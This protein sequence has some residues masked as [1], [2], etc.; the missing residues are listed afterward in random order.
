MKKLFTDVELAGINA[1]ANVRKS[2]VEKGL[3]FD[4]EKK[5]TKVSERL[6]ALKEI[7]KRALDYKFSLIESEY[8]SEEQK[9]Q[10]I[11]EKINIKN[12]DDSK[13]PVVQKVVVRNNKNGN[14]KSKRFMRLRK[15]FKKNGN[16]NENNNNNKKRR[17]FKKVALIGALVGIGSLAITNVAKA[18]TDFG[19]KMYYEHVKKEKMAPYREMLE[20]VVLSNTHSMYKTRDVGGGEHESYYE[21]YLSYDKI[22]KAIKECDNPDLALYTLYHYYGKTTDA[23]YEGITNRTCKNLEFVNK[24]GEVKKGDLYDFASGFNKEN[25]TDE[26]ILKAYDQI[27]D[28]DLKYDFDSELDKL[29]YRI[30]VKPKTKGLT[31]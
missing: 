28:T 4:S 14:K 11:L 23:L 2:L 6:D 5:Y 15:L 27:C 22:A 8:E 29:E 13:S 12:I 18:S 10:P 7:Q 26:E 1:K 3:D 19:E 31:K 21:Y 16:G 25:K 30:N 17:V 20:H 9:E 24:D